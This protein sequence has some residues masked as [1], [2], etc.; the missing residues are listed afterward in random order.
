VAQP[1]WTDDH[2][3]Q[4]SLN[5]KTNSDVF[6]GGPAPQPRIRPDSALFKVD[7]A[8]PNAAS[9]RAAA[10]LPGVISADG[11]WRAHAMELPRPPATPPGGTDFERR[12][13]ARFKGRQF[14]WMRFQSDGQGP[15]GGIAGQTFDQHFNGHGFNM[16]F[17]AG[18]RAPTRIPWAQLR[19][20]L[21]AG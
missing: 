18:A 7:V 17:P 10:G 2:M 5:A 21:S 12:H 6:V 13:E 20:I 3:L 1:R 9:V 15:V 16:R 8:T 11:K 4:Y 19:H 14:D